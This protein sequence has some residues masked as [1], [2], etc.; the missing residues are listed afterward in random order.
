MKIKDIQ[1]SNNAARFSFKGQECRAFAAEGKEH[2]SVI[3]T[4]G[5]GN[6]LMQRVYFKGTDSETAIHSTL[7]DFCSVPGWNIEI[8][9]LTQGAAKS[10]RRHPVLD[11]L[12]IALTII[13]LFTALFLLWKN[14]IL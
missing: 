10:E 9:E 6:T 11:V 12:T 1:I 2:E 7:I 13:L 4:D 8:P 3:I 5:N 14:H